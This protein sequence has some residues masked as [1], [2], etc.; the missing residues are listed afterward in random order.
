MDWTEAR[1]QTLDR[2]RRIRDAV[3][4]AHPADLIAE[5]NSICGLC[6]RA[7]SDAALEGDFH[8]CHYCVAY[9]QLGGCSATDLQMTE[10]LSRRDW[11]RARAVAT[12]AIAD[13]EGL[14]LPQT[15]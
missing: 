2:W 3:G 7:R 11:D 8:T 6:S 14:E 12:Q 15:A 1:E 10:A 9:Y 5:V 4:K 13:L